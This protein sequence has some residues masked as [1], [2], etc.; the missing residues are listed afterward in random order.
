MK[1]HPLLRAFSG[2]KTHPAAVA[3]QTARL[4]WIFFGMVDE[5]LVYTA[6]K[7]TFYN[8]VQEIAL[9]LNRQTNFNFS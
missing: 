7:A 5:S 6:G 8:S 1:V 3:E 4:T 9:T 2:P